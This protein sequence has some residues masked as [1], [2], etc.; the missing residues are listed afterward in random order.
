[1][2][3]ISLSPFLR[4]TNVAPG[5]GITNIPVYVNG[6]FVY[7]SAVNRVLQLAANLYEASTNETYPSVF[8][9]VFTI[10]QYTN[11]FIVGYSNVTGVLVGSPANDIQFS[12]PYDVSQLGYLPRN[13]AMLTNIYGVPW[14]IGAKANLPGFNQLTMLNTV[15]ATRALQVF[16]K[17]PDGPIYT[18]H[19]YQL[20]ISNSI[21]ASFWNSYSND[22]VSSGQLSVLVSDYVSMGLTNSDHPGIPSV[23]V[24]SNTFAYITNRW[25]GSR[26]PHL[27]G[28]PRTANPFINS[29]IS[30]SFT[31]TLYSGA[32]YKTGAK[33][34]ALPTDPDP[35]ESNNI[36]CD[37]LPQLG[38]LTTNW[39]RAI[40][41]DQGHVIDYVQLRGPMDATNFTTA[42]NDPNVTTTSSY[43]WSTNASGTANNGPS[44][45]Y[46][47][48]IGVSQGIE[49]APINA[50]WKPENYPGNANSVSAGTAYFNAFFQPAPHSFTDIY[51]NTAY[52]TNQVVQAGYT[53]TRTIFVPYLYQVN[54]PLVHFLAD[55]LNA[56]T[57]G[58]WANGP[59]ANGIWHQMDGVTAT[60]PL[61]A[62][63]GGLDFVT[64]GRYQPWGV[65]APSSLLTAAYNFGNPYNPAY[66]DPGVWDPDYW[67]FPTNKYPT[68]GWIGRV[69]R[70]SPWQTVYLKATNIVA[71]GYATGTNTWAVWTGNGNSYDA[72]NSAPV[73]DRLLFDVF[74]T[75]PNDNAARGTLS[76][77]QTNLP[78]WSGVL[79]GVVVLTNTYIPR[80]GSAYLAAGN[81][82]P[83]VNDG[84]NVIQPAGGVGANSQLAQLVAAINSQRANSHPFLGFTN[85]DGVV[86]AFEHVGDILSVPQLTVQSPYLNWS[87]NLQQAYGINDAAYEWLPQQAMGLLRGTSTPRYVIYGYGQA[88]RPAAN[89]L[90]TS[91]GNF[92]LV[93]NYQVVAE[94]A[95]RAVVS[96]Q[97][98]INL[99][100]PYPVTNYTTRVESYNVLPAD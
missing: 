12:L 56:G 40:I 48:Q 90:D 85:G 65:A 78:A 27:I 23:M 26:W 6:Q 47:N 61:P 100:G 52:A 83:V 46:V 22:Y 28:E 10:D 76:V 81:A 30:T 59:V 66:K 8:R 1:M 19:L 15:Q 53:A 9:P 39:L 21:S 16:R 32:I 58:Y 20:Y 7:S 63:P 55:D 17:T 88:L 31:N 5:F 3:N 36:S 79:S 50:I 44:W 13:T 94:S 69:H 86:G 62:P 89:G 35:W 67:N 41:V 4:W 93:T 73:Q 11:L 87:N 49:N 25:A 60:A 38:L 29:F 91:S 68:V 24:F 98:Q 71:S 37:P 2:T 80:S 64:K 74:T 84:Y 34:W 72:A 14:I 54:D 82:I 57:S 42:L 51:G 18:N 45:G 70:G 77:N 99:S 96:V 33:A 43:L 75:R 97:K 92:G 95:V